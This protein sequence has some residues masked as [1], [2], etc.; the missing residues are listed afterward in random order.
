MSI[1]Y[2]HVHRVRPDVEYPQS[3]DSDGTFRGR[4]HD[5]P[6]RL[7][8]GSSLGSPLGSLATWFCLVAGVCGNFTLMRN[9]EVSYWWQS[10]GGVPPRAAAPAGPPGA[11]RA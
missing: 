9:G 11:G 10:L 6:P 4:P 1:N 2:E 8:P 7:L 3:H 5:T